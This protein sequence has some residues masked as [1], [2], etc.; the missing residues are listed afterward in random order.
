MSDNR[1]S[2]RY[3]A[4]A[5]ARISGHPESQGLLKNIS[6]TGCCVEYTVKADILPNTRYKLEIIPEE[7]MGIDKFELQV[8]QRWVH[9]DGYSTDVGFMIA[10]SPKGSHFQDYVDYLAYHKMLL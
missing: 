7:A 2:P 6:I 1:N 9:S 8:E 10:A 4:L 5:S 3:R